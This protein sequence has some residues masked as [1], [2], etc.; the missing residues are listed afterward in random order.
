VGAIGREGKLIDDAAHMRLAAN[1][2]FKAG[3]VETERLAA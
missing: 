3:L 1:V 2:L